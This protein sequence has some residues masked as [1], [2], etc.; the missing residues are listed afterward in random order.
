[1]AEGENL[2]AFGLFFLGLAFVGTAAV[3]AHFGHLASKE[4]HQE[5]F[6]AAA[7][8]ALG[9]FV[10]G[11]VVRWY[12]WRASLREEKT[13][14]LR[15]LSK[16]REKVR[17]ARFLMTAHKS[18]RTWTEQTR[19]LVMLVPRITDLQEAAVP[20]GS[21]LGRAK[22]HLESLKD[23]YWE[24]HDNVATLGT[25]WDKIRDTVPSSTELVMSNE[26]PLLKAL[27]ESIGWLK[28]ELRR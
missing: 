15:E 17:N 5:I 14:M 16:I 10:V 24:K 7:E 21:A 6:A 3:T 19:E 25:Q 22:V 12:L 2:G 27:D 26:S 4:I 1:M 18:A 8:S 23:E 11:V 20:N 13:A 9:V 28:N